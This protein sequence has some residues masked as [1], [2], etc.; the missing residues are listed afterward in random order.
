[1][2]VSTV[3]DRVIESETARLGSKRLGQLSAMFGL[4]GSRY[5]KEILCQEGVDPILTSDRRFLPEIT[6]EKYAEIGQRVFDSSL[7][8]TYLAWPSTASGQSANSM[9]TAMKLSKIYEEVLDIVV[10][11]DDII[12]QLIKMRKSGL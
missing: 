1:M 12:T 10:P 2:L 11:V 4:T 5:A 8:L 3:F 7:S 9:A 6:K